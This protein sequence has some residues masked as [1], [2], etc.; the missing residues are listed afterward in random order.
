[1]AGADFLAGILE[2]LG[3]VLSGYG[4]INLKADIT[5]KQEAAKKPEEIK[6][7]EMTHPPKIENGRTIPTP[8][9]TWEDIINYRQATSPYYIGPGGQK[10]RIPG[11]PSYLEEQDQINVRKAENLRNQFKTMGLS[12]SDLKWLKNYELGRQ[13][14][15]RETG[16]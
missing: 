14:R 4:A 7:W 2:Q 3:T 16:R 5:R 12:P 6:L 9:P 8:Q 10:G 11:E 1:M 15:L 13:K